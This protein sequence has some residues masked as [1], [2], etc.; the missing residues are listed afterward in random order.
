M[1]LID[2]VGPRDHF[3]PGRTRADRDPVHLAQRIDR[4]ETQR[5][6]AKPRLDMDGLAILQVYGTSP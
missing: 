4:R 3:S 5:E 2:V 1:C 6:L